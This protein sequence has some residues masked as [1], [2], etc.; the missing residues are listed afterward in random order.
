MFS[1][2]KEFKTLLKLNVSKRSS[3]FDLMGEEN[4]FVIPSINFFALMASL[5]NRLFLILLNRMVWLNRRVGLSW[6]C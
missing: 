2:F 5:D 6:K 1:K 4:T 3:V